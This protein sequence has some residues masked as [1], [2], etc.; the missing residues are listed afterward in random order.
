M[1]HM[2]EKK[3]AYKDLAE[4]PEERNNLEDLGI[5]GKIILKYILKGI[6][7]KRC[8]LDASVPEYG[9][10]A[11]CYENGNESLSFIYL[12]EFLD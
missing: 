10:L 6:G 11:G 4:K 7:W 5:D 12:W 9:P 1:A 2:G 8:G 3:N